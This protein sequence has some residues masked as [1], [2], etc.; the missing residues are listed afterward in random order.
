MRRRFGYRRI[1]DLPRPQF[2]VVNHKRAYRLYRQANLTVRHRKKGKRPVNER[3]P[4]Q[5]ART[6]SQ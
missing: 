6:S 1:H 5:L 4:L 3:V 2:P